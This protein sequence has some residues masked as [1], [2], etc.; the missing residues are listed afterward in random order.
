MPS[1]PCPIDLA[2]RSNLLIETLQAFFYLSAP[3]P[4]TFVFLQTS[5]LLFFLSAH[6]SYLFRGIL[7]R[8]LQEECEEACKRSCLCFSANSAIVFFQCL[9]LVIF[10]RHLERWITRGVWGEGACKS[11]QEKEHG[12][13]LIGGRRLEKYKVVADLSGERALSLSTL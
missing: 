11:L 3:A 8:G 4:F 6:V 5:P 7:R 2:R 9:C 10:S 13:S 1:C 12:R